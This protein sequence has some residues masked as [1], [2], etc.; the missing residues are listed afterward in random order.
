VDD[1]VEGLVRTLGAAGALKRTAI[2]YTS[3]SAIA[4]SSL[5]NHHKP[6]Y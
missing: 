2:I 1:L 3:E 5:K 4:R 6:P